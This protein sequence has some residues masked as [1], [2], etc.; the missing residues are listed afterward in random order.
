MCDRRLFAKIGDERGIALVL[1]LFQLMP[2]P[3]GFVA[4]I[5]PGARHVIDT[6]ASKP[7]ELAL[8]MDAVETAHEA[9][10]LL[11]YVCASTVAAIVFAVNNGHFAGA[12]W[13][14]EPPH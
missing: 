5:S 4:F 12:F 9:L 7:S 6:L 13:H 11:L 14:N 3:V 10:K 8:T 2:L 1:T